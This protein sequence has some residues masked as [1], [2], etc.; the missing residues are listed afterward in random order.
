MDRFGLK[1]LVPLIRLDELQGTNNTNN[2]D[3]TEKIK[4]NTDENIEKDTENSGENNV[5]D[6]GKG[7]KDET[8]KDSDG[9]DASK[10]KQ[11][12]PES[13]EEDNSK[14]ETT[15]SKDSSSTKKDDKLDTSITT[16]IS[17]TI[18]HSLTIGA[19]L[20]SMLHSLGLPRDNKRHR[21]L[22]TFQSPW[23][24]T[25]RS[26][27]QPRFFIPS[28]FSN[29]SNV[30]QCNTTPPTFNNIELDQQRVALFQDETLFYLF[31]KHP[32]T[33]IQELTYLE[34]R[35]R[36]WRF[37]KI[38]KTWLTKDPMMEPI[39]AADGF[40]ERGSYVFFDPQRWEKCQRE[41]ILFYNAIM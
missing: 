2:N 34:L 3:T 5:E 8:K 18:D 7:D 23:A 9:Q 26:E 38:L 24:E 39:V 4:T 28:S 27:V 35:K 19:D 33:V 32:G 22:D 31:Y 1:A 30:L 6:Q 10:D 20:S 16:T 14:K 25:S 37:H 13:K 12:E 29:I 40:S 17:S 41:F 36:N 11:E 15:T 21:I